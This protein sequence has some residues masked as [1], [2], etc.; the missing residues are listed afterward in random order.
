[1][2]FL[3][4]HS[5]RRSAE[6]HPRSLAFKFERSELDYAQLERCSNGLARLLV[7]SGVKR[8]DRVGLFMPKCMEMPIA[9]YG[10]MKAG[11]AY[12]P[13]D[14]Q[15]PASR[16]RA[17]IAD[18][19][20]RHLLTQ[21]SMRRVLGDVL[22]APTTVEHVIGMPADAPLA[23]S[24]AAWETVYAAAA[25][26]PPDVRILEDDLAYIIY[27]SGSTGAPK[28]IMHAHRSG[29]AFARLSAALYGLRNGDRLSN[30]PPLHSDM[31]TFDFFS[32]PLAGASTIIIP[33]E[34]TKLP[35]S[36]SQLVQD[37]ALTVWYSVVSALI[38]LSTRGVLE[39]RD[40][41]SLRWVLFCGEPM[42]AKSLRMLMERLPRA[43]FSN[44]YGPA[45]VNQCTYYNVPEPPRNDAESVPIGHVWGNTED[46]VIDADDALV[47]PGEV[48]ELVIR[49]ATM[50]RG[51]WNRADLNERAYYCRT[52]LPGYEQRFY[53][54][55]D[56]VRLGADGEYRFLGR[57][58]RQIK[59][60]GHRVELDEVEAALCAH[61][62]VEEAAAFAVPD[63]E[64]GNRIEAAVVL[65]PDANIDAAGLRTYIKAQLPG[66]A[67]PGKLVIVAT[68]PRTPTGKIDRPRL[69]RSALAE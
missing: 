58:D 36:L 14:P 28:G 57:K 39:S 29:L 4:P 23:M 62:A 27:T 43:R 15:A 20:I 5:V 16:V 19:G 26:E 37:E 1:M 10:V 32:G 9:V 61:D 50:M 49:S 11:A 45:E 21:P 18:C 59:T 67:L 31:S 46:L 7:E 8:H 6:R 66:Y 41:S 33:E 52:A 44:V 2:A 51:Y 48:G 25:D 54:T 13:L 68:L 3:L 30:H 69:A 55:G 65:A 63:S 40:L 12:V 64:I 35:A 53:R 60:R 24:C 42:P 38:Q 47:A 56:L 34:Y 17:M 22:S